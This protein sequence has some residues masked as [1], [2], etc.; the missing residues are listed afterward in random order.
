MLFM[1]LINDVSSRVY[2]CGSFICYLSPYGAMTMHVGLK[3]RFVLAHFSAAFK[4]V[5]E[6]LRICASRVA[7]DNMAGH[8]SAPRKVHCEKMPTAVADTRSPIRKCSRC[9]RSQ[10]GCETWESLPLPHAADCS[11]RIQL[12]GPSP[13]SGAAPLG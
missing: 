1:E 12:R 6:C 13:S 4:S 7:V 8:V 11:S 5:T 3:T 10:C 2:T 9:L